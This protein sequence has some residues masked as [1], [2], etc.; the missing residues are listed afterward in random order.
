MQTQKTIF[1]KTY[2]NYLE[3]I[4]EI[5]FK[6]VAHNLGVKIVRN[7]III[8]LF[9]NEYEVSVAGIADTAGK[10]LSHDI[11]VIACANRWRTKGRTRCIVQGLRRQIRYTR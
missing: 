5:P 7:R 2:K 10:K 8:P 6:S 4:R 3:Q 9:I 11:G 1:E